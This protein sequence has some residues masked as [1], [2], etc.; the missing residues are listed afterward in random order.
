MKKI[1]Y[2]DGRRIRVGGVPAWGPVPSVLTP[3]TMEA[4]G[5]FEEF[6]GVEQLNIGGNSHDWEF[7]IQNAAILTQAD[8]PGGV[9]IITCGGTDNDSGQIILGALAGGGGFR[10]AAD[11]HLWFEALIRAGHASADEFNYF[12]GLIK[13]VNAAILGN[14][15]G[16][17][18]NDNMV[19]FSVRDTDA[20][21]SFMGDDGSTEVINPLGAARIVDNEWH[22]LG[23]YISG[24]D[25]VTVYYDGGVVAAGALVAANIPDGVGLMPAIAVKDGGGAAETIE[26]DYVMCVQLR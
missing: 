19:G 1:G 13:P 14:N 11:K 3:G 10:I 23:F 4:Y 17:F 18:P 8:V 21:W 7:W 12:V 15:G 22:S 16:A 6:L 5:I 24:V 26:F 20:N 25:T 2:I 9:G